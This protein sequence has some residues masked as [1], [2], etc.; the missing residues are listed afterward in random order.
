MR[1]GLVLSKV[2][3]HPD[4]WSYPWCKA[5]SSY[6]TDEQL[7]QTFLHL[8]KKEKTNFSQARYTTNW[9]EILLFMLHVMLG[10]ADNFE[11]EYLKDYKRAVKR[12]VKDVRTIWVNKSLYNVFRTPSAEDNHELHFFYLIT[13]NDTNMWNLLLPTRRE[14]FSF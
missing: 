8:N 7:L 13:S 9:N 6:F 4:P 14:S 12:A 3:L 11:G 1:L 10:K 5:M 2:H